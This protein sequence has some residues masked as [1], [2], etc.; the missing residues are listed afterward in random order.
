MTE[1]TDVTIVMVNS[2]GKEI[3]RAVDEAD[4]KE[5]MNYTKTLN[6]SNLAAGAYFVTVIAGDEQMVRKVI[7]LD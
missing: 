2:V 3:L 5:N 4:V 7:K 6:V 1:P